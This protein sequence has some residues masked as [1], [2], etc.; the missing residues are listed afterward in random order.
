MT[1][2]NIITLN[3]NELNLEQINPNTENFRNWDELVLSTELMLVVTDMVV[4]LETS[5]SYTFSLNTQ[6]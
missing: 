4:N 6:K 2:D 3:I 5:R 1:D